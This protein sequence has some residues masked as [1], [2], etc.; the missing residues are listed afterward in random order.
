MVMELENL[1]N[2]Y[3]VLEKAL[4]KQTIINKQ[5]IEGTVSNRSNKILHYDMLV[6]IINVLCF[7]M[8]I[9]LG[10]Y[11]KDLS[12]FFFSLAAL[13]L[14]YL[15][16]CIINYLKFNKIKDIS[17][18]SVEKVDSLIIKY[19]RFLRFD[20]F[21]N[22]SILIVFMSWLA[23][24][25][26]DILVSHNRLWILVLIFLA[27]SVMIIYSFKWKLEQIKNLKKEV[28]M[29]EEIYGG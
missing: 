11:R 25:Y 21:I 23:V 17:S 29:Y 5:I 12:I 8:L 26:Y 9:G 28:S 10:F 22:M 3:K 20:M 16:I 1:K 4:E 7:P 13:M 19:L 14:P 15:V 27:T 18:S 2:R 24:S 6:M